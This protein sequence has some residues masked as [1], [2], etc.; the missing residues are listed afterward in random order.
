MANTSTKKK[1]KKLGGLWWWIIILLIGALTN[2]DSN[3]DLQRFFWRIRA[4]FY[5]VFHIWMEQHQSIVIAIGA[6]IVFLA[7]L[8]VILAAV[9]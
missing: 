8:L 3:T 5:W 4:W 6:G 1:K 7:A 2:M 9:L